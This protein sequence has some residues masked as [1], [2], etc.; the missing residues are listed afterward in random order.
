MK[1]IFIAVSAGVCLLAGVASPAKADGSFGGLGIVGWTAGGFIAIA[2]TYE[3]SDDYEVV[4]APF[5]YPRFG[6]AGGR[7]S[8]RG[9]DD[10]RY[11]LINGPRLA[12][13]PLVGYKSDRD[14][15]D[16]PLLA[17]L[18]DVE[19]G[20]V[21][22]GFAE[23]KLQ[24]WLTFDVS[25]HRTVTGDVDGGQVR[26]GLASETPVTPALTLL[27]RVGA[28]YA[29]D[30]YMGAYFG[31]TAAQEATSLA[32]LPEYDAGAGI[33]DVHVQLGAD[34]KLSQTWGLKISGRYGYLVGDAGDSPVV[35]TRD[36]FS[37]S[38]VITYKF[39]GR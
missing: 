37:G 33:K 10:I 17:G 31:I 5:I 18:G 23:F 28:T 15:D 8:V 11:R 30:A 16:G 27:A 6:G 19:G 35:E 22:G 2:P 20:V 24:P 9:A 13:G 4:G 12:V 29:D 38:A 14:E 3:G 32:L 34:I 21:V 1:S 39:G 7:L 36:Q 25:Y 26:F